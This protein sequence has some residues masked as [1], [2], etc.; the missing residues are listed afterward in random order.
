MHFK[1]HTERHVP[2]KTS[3]LL[4]RIIKPMNSLLTLKC[5]YVNRWHKGSFYRQNRWEI[6]D[7][8]CKSSNLE[9]TDSAGNLQTN[10]NHQK[11]VQTSAPNL[12]RPSV[13]F[14][15]SK[16]IAVSTSSWQ[17]RVRSNPVAWLQPKILHFC[18][19]G[20]GFSLSEHQLNPIHQTASF[21]ADLATFG[22]LPGQGQI[23]PTTVANQM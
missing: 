18:G 11:Q 4:Q 3:L 1:W 23:Q 13:L 19:V 15:L 14:C 16:S 21:S 10:I 9:Y 12:N 20:G 22:L 7:K 5:L 2:R 17:S 8:A 6:K